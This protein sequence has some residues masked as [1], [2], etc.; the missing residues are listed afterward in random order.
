MPAKELTEANCHLRHS[1]S[2]PLL[3]DAIF[4]W[5]SDRILFT[6]TTLKN[7]AAESRMLEQKRFF[8]H[9]NDVQSVANGDRWCIKIGLR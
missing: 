6:L 9:N 7:I 5:L 3:I 4:I 2:K 1:C 8:S